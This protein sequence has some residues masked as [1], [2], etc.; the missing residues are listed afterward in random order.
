MGSTFDAAFVSDALPGLFAEFGQD[1]SITRRST[2]ITASAIVD[3]QKV[4][5]KDAQRG[6]VEISRNW[7]TLLIRVSQYD[8]GDGVVE[9][10]SVETISIEDGRSFEPRTP[11]GKEQCWEYT[12]GTSTV[13]K[14]YVEEVAA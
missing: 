10:T 7:V 11:D 3:T 4:R 9:P 13:Y 2:T 12:D 8:F 1:A 5:S 14:I 6:D